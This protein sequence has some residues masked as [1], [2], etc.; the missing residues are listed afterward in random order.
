MRSDLLQRLA[1]NRC[2]ALAATLAAKAA[3]DSENDY[4]AFVMA[5]GFG[6]YATSVIY[7]R[8]QMEGLMSPR[9]VAPLAVLSAIGLGLAFVGIIPH[10]IKLLYYFGLHH[11]FNETF[12]SGRLLQGVS[13]RDM[14][15]YRLTSTLFNI[16]VYVAMLFTTQ[17]SRIFDEQVL[18]ALI[19]LT[20]VPYARTVWRLGAGKSG[21]VITDLVSAEAIGLCLAALS[22]AGGVPIGF[23]DVVLYHFLFWCLYPLAKFQTQGSTRVVRYL[24][25]NLGLTLVAFAASPVVFFNYELFGSW[26]LAVFYALSYFHITT[27][28][29]LSNQHP[30]WIVQWFRGS[31]PIL[32]G[33]P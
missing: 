16:A 19:V 5:V 11:V 28:F 7:A 31:A 20:G 29:A 32:R 13:A 26:Y 23:M 9:Y 12:I 25:A 17:Y 30:E 21:A 24:S 3:F 27:S 2:A 22:L 18:W 10:T 6:H 8:S 4:L 1:F 15:T 14:K 33:S